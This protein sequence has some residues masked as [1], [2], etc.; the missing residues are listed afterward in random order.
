MKI[1]FTAIELSEGKVKFQDDNLAALA[2]KDS[3]KKVSPFFVEFM[4]DEFVHAD[5]IVVP[6]D[7]ILDLLILDMELIESRLTRIE[8]DAEKVL[9]DRCLEELEGETPLC[10]I[11]WSD[12]QMEILKIL[13]PHSLKPVVR[14]DDQ[15]EINT[16]I[17]L[18]L[19][20]ANHMFFY[21]S[22]PQESHAW[23]VN[24]GSDIVTCAAKIHSDLARG[25]IKGDVVAFEDYMNCHSFNECKSKG[26][27][28]LVD[29]DYI[30]QPN[31]VI[32]IRFNA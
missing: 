22:G 1:G 13:S 18:A 12:D 4:R 11:S 26:V 10:D 29:R 25:F 24:K 30:V 27:A 20:K 17:R 21:T 31:E 9:L 2:K 23:P 3:P 7:N 6:G 16:I 14:V 19:E 28:K 32:E 5:V 15:M 8:S